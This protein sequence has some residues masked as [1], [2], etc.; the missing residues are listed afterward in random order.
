MLDVLT[1]VA[2]RL[3]ADAVATARRTELGAIGAISSFW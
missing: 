2:K 3:H 1:V